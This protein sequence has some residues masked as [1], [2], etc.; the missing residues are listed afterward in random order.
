VGGDIPAGHFVAARTSGGASKKPF[1]EPEN[2]LL[3]TRLIAFCFRLFRCWVF[4]GFRQQPA[5]TYY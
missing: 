4:I 5:E 2:N 1:S 3:P